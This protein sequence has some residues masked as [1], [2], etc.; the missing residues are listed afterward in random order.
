[1]RQHFYLS[2][3]VAV[4]LGIGLYYYYG[5]SVPWDSKRYMPAITQQR[6]QSSAVC[7]HFRA[8]K[9]PAQ[10][11]GQDVFQCRSCQRLVELGL[12]NWVPNIPDQYTLTDLGK[13]TYTESEIG[14]ETLYSGKFIERN[15]CFGQARLKEIIKVSSPTQPIG[16]GP[17]II[18]VEYTQEVSNLHPLLHSPKLTMADNLP[19]LLPDSNVTTPRL[20]TF[21]PTGQ[22]DGVE[23]SDT[24]QLIGTWIGIANKIEREDEET[25]QKRRGG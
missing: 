6:Q 7:M 1:M 17:N 25:L 13:Q 5:G 18:Y 15:F 24:G 10:G 9:L 20:V 22:G 11:T 8:D 19:V 16:G 23:M 14:N 12:I 3:A 2:T 21:Q 4:T